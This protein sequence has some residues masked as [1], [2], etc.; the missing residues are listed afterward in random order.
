MSEGPLFAMVEVKPLN[1][2]QR[3]FEHFGVTTIV[4]FAAGSGAM[5][6]AAA[7]AQDYEG[8]AANVEHCDWLDATL[9]KCVQYLAGQDKH[10]SQNLGVTDDET[11][12]KIVKFFGGTMMEARRILAP[13]DATE[14][15][16]GASSDDDGDEDDDSDDF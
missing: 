8:I 14:E 15:V 4:D 5:A 7:G 3:L 6:I 13:P 11:T 1:L 16:E 10:F 9:D 12:E 2:I